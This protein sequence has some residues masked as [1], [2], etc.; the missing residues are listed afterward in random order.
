MPYFI[1]TGTNK[2]GRIDPKI[3]KSD[4][5]GLGTSGLR[6]CVAVVIIGEISKRISLTHFLGGLERDYSSILKEIEWVGSP[7]II[8]LAKNTEG[9]FAGLSEV[10]KELNIKSEDDFA[11]YDTETLIINFLRKHNLLKNLK[12]RLNTLSGQVLVTREGLLTKVPLENT[13]L[14]Y[15]DDAELQNAIE[16]MNGI[17][18]NVLLSPNLEFDGN[19][20]H[21]QAFFAQ[22]GLYV[23]NLVD[24][25]LKQMDYD[26]S[27]ENIF[28]ALTKLDEVFKEMGSTLGVRL[29][30][31]GAEPS[32][33]RDELLKDIKRIITSGKM[34]IIEFSKSI[35]DK[36]DFSTQRRVHFP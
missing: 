16:M 29:A 34:P 8:R 6:T 12:S 20:F 7:F 5:V 11:K 1:M 21:Q 30:I 14:L 19:R 23:L 31:Y 36:I 22:A 15:R 32:A 26:Y 35:T 9:M 33:R 28:L 18:S 27:L 10:K 25:Y 17:Y 3:T 4:V 2:T 13:E 24:Y